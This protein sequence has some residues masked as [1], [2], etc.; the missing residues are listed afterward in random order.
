MD[1]SPP[2][3]TQGSDEQNPMT[4]RTASEWMKYVKHSEEGHLVEKS[5]P[6]LDSAKKKKKKWKK[7]VQY[8]FSLHRREC[9]AGKY[10]WPLGLVVFSIPIALGTRVTYFHILTS[11][12][13]DHVT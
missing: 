2:T 9:F 4:C 8:L 12:D 7:Y 10:S 5:D 3:P 6:L 1:I 11:E 13:I